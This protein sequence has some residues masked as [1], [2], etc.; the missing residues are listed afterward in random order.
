MQNHISLSYRRMISGGIFRCQHLYAPQSISVFKCL[1]QQCKT[2]NQHNTI[3]H[4]SNFVLTIITSFQHSCS[5]YTWQ[6]TI[7]HSQFLDQ[8]IHALTYMSHSSRAMLHNSICSVSLNICN[9]KNKSEGKIV[10]PTSK[11]LGQLCSS[12]I[13]VFCNISNHFIN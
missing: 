11:S 13:D 2:K 9:L 10:G 1:H 3:S 7:V 12:H 4:F 5:L 6:F 8:Q